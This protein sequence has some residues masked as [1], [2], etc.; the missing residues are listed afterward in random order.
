MQHLIPITL[1][2]M[3]HEFNPTPIFPYLFVQHAA[4]CV[5]DDLMAARER[6][7]HSGGAGAGGGGRMERI[8]VVSGERVESP[9]VESARRR[10]RALARR[11][12]ALLQRCVTS[13]SICP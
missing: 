12:A 6:P 11:T 9:R 2:E 1:C 13:A 7:S 3:Q 5:A 4:A 8:G 10:A